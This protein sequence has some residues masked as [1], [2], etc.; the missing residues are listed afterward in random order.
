[1]YC[2]RIVIKRSDAIDQIKIEYDDGT[3]WSCGHDG[4]KADNRPA[5]MTK[6]EHLVRVTHERF[7][8]YKSAAAA[9]GCRRI[10]RCSCNRS[11]PSASSTTGGGNRASTA[12]E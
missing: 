1:M 12:L 9:I 6:G 11:V 8:N 10:A 2:R 5:V 4:G 7:V 3:Q